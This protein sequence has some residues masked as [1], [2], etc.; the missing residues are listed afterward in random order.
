M[1]KVGCAIIL[2]LLLNSCDTPKSLLFE[3]KTN[4]SISI[5]YYCNKGHRIVDVPDNSYIEKDTLKFKIPSSQR[6]GI[7]F[8]MGGWNKKVIADFFSPSTQS[9]MCIISEKDTIQYT[10]EK[11]VSLLQKNRKG[12]KII[13]LVVE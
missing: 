3:N 10:G 2:F 5:A 8:G 6:D 1:Y 13:K 9:I 12:R 7:C 4:D 11:L